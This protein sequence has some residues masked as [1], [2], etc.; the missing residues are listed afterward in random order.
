VTSLHA[1]D[2]PINVGWGSKATQFHGSLGKAAAA[3][4]SQPAPPPTGTS[5]D[6]DSLPRISWRGDGAYFCIS[7]VSSS[8]PRR[9]LRIYAHS[10]A[11][12][13]TSEAVAGLEHPLSW[14]PSGNLIAAS[15]R[16]GKGPGLAPGPEGRHDIVFFERNG[17]RHGEF[18]LRMK[19]RDYRVKEIRWNADSAVLGVWIE[20]KD[21]GDV[22]QL[23]T[24]GNYYWYLKQEIR[25]PDRGRFVSVEWH[26]ERAFELYL[27]SA[28]MFF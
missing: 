3:A 27:T 7:S 17:L 21:D 1:L 26:P 11:L 13:S 28:G 16:F 24:T 6:D 9:M 14:R 19:T 15:Q 8:S 12:Q 23:W 20:T 18:S 10:G 4:A 5:P 2:A 25:L 22:L